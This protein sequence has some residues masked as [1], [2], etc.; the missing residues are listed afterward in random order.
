MCKRDKKEL[1]K[2]QLIEELDRALEENYGEVGARVVYEKIEEYGDPEHGPAVQDLDLP[3]AVV[4]VLLKR[5]IQRLYRFQ[6]EA[7]KHVLSGRNVVISAGTGTGK[8]EAF[9]LPLLKKVSEEVG[10]NPKSLILY[11][12]KALARDQ[13]KRFSDYTVFG[14]TSVSIYD[15][16]TPRSVRARIASSPTTFVITNPDMIHVGLVYSPH[17]RKFVKSANTMVF[18]ELHVYEGVLGSHVHHLFQRIKMCRESAPQVVASSATIGNPKEF[19]ESLF[20]EDFV[21]VRGAIMRRGTAVHALV[22]TGLLSRW[23]IAVF[24]SK[25]LASRGLRFI[26]FVDSQQLAEMLTNVLRNRHGVEVM[27]HRAGIPAEVRRRVES[28]LRDG[29]LQGVVST[30]TLELGIDIGSL[31]AVVLAAPP[32][33]YAKYLQRAGRAGRRRKGYIFTILS[34]DP[35]DSYYARN[36]EKFLDQDIPPSAIEPRNEEVIKTHL[37]AFLLQQGRT[38]ENDLPQVWRSVLGNLLAEGLVRIRGG[39]VLPQ[40]SEARKFLSLREGIRSPGPVIK[41]VDLSTGQEIAERELPRA[42]LELY[43]GSLYLYLGRP[44]RTLELDLSKLRAYLENA[45]DALEFYTRPLYTVDVSNFEVLAE[46]DSE[47]G[48]KLAYAHVELEMVVEGYVA[49]DVFGGAILEVRHY[50]RPITF[51]YPTKAVL[52]KFEEF[53]ELGFEGMA[54]AYHAIEHAVISAARVVCGAGLGDMGGVSYPSGDIVFYDADMGGSG[55]AKLLYSRFEKAVDVAYSIVS[56]CDCDD[57]CPRCVYSPYCGNNNRVLSR[58]KASYVLEQT[59]K[60]KPIVA[61]EP[62]K[63]KYGIPYV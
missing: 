5:G 58:R 14:V 34:D 60:S 52:A 31:D 30:P 29:R 40:F 42:L 54:E 32:P 53:V 38:I 51:R 46:R 55:L 63:A 19:A 49:R 21:E 16:D 48:V 8:T 3:E 27:V 35:V 6:F 18:D 50:S 26:V 59:T 47:L 4:R 39:V 20:G 11:P 17:V 36:P 12:T 7:Y 56:K 24:V 23:S 9:F 43:P 57:G 61:Q 1:H 45:G 2:D 41:L 25:F 62:L 15:G 37:V 10:S 28:D 44:Y 13:L 22:S 33:S